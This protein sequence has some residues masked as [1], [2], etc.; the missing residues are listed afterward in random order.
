[1]ELDEFITT[2]IKSII[3]SVND[4][5]EF[6]EKNGAIVNPILLENEYTQYSSIWRKGRKDGRRFLTKVES[7]SKEAWNF[8]CQFEKKE[9]DI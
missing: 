7:L 2:T 1:M 4:T 9:E 3:T 8:L 6:A 5:V